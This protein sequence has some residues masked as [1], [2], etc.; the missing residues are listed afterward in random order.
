MQV[1][2]SADRHAV[3]LTI[4]SPSSQPAVSAGLPASTDITRTPLSTVSS[5]WR[6]R[7]RGSGVFCPATPM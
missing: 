1:V 6:T 2:D 4:T 3:P 5:K 7:R